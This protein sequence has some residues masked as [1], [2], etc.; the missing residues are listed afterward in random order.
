MGAAV[1]EPRMLSRLFINRSR[2]LRNGWWI[3]L[4]FIVLT[5]LLLPL[6]LNAHGS[7]GVSIYAQSGVVLAAS[8]VCQ[9]L[10][11]RPLA[12][13]FGAFD[14]RWPRDLL[15]GGALGA[16]LMLIPAIAL[17]GVGVVS[18]RLPPVSSRDLLAVLALLAAAAAAEELLFRGFVFQRLL[19]GLGVWPAQLIVGAFFVLTHADAL[20]AVGGLGWLAGANI[21]LASIL[22]GLAYLRTRSLAMP[23]GLHLAANLAEGPLLGFGVS[24]EDEPSL[25]APVFGEAPHWLTGGSFGLEASAPGLIVVAAFAAALWRPQ[26]LARLLGFGHK[27]GP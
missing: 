10:R 6:L 7:A 16:A 15:V 17:L 9:G 21:F 8:L 5:G 3:A 19:D 11:R 25:L 22:F 1:H 23:L 14:W 20:G 12:E 2:R 26:T 13:L 24:G 27:R 18:W 4:F